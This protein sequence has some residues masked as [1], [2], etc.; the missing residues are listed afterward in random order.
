MPGELP[1]AVPLRPVPT[2]EAVLSAGAAIRYPALALFAD[3][4][5]AA[6]REFAIITD[7]QPAVYVTPSLFLMSARRMCF[8]TLPVAVMG[9][10]DTISKRSGSFCVASFCARR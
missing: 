7:N 8:W 10:A 6:V 9:M 1:F 3:R 2:P 5:A 4:V